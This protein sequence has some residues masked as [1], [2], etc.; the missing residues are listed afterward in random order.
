MNVA[1]PSLLFLF[2]T[3]FIFWLN[4]IIYKRY[5]KIWLMPAIPTSILIIALVEGTSTAYPVYFQDTKW[6]VWLLGPATVAFALPI[7]KNRHIVQRYWPALILGS[8][9]SIFV[10][11]VTTL[12]IAK[13]FRLDDEITRSLLSR[14]VS[15]PFAL[16]ASTHLGGSAQLTGLFVVI[17][18]LFGIIFGEIFLTIIPLK[19]RVARGAPLGSA[20]HGFGLSIARTIGVEEG[21]V[22]SLTM[23][24]SGIL[25]VFLSPLIAWFVT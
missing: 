14:S 22:A 2:A 4:K 12:C 16:E 15:T 20:A 7:Y 23:I 24:F 19:T 18:G 1:I 25:M 11:V 6:L 9:V 13:L 17:T 5:K 21:A 10:S 8:L 3:I